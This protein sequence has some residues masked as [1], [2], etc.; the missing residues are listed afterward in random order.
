M[1]FQPQ[2]ITYDATYDERPDG[3][4][5]IMGA[6]ATHVESGLS[7][8][9]RQFGSYY[10]NREAARVELEAKL[11]R[12][13]EVASSA[14]PVGEGSEGRLTHCSGVDGGLVGLSDGTEDGAP[15]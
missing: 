6:V 14:S 15:V 5:I 10:R 2:E 1:F 11:T 12:R 9:C 8:E 3:E 7:V 4:P 13:A